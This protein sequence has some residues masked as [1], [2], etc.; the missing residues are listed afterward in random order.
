M[1]VCILE[2]YLNMQDVMDVLADSNIFIIFVNLTSNYAI[3][4]ILCYVV[5]FYSLYLI[6]VS[7]LPMH[8]D[9]LSPPIYDAPLEIPSPLHWFLPTNLRTKFYYVFS[10]LN[11]AAITL[12]YFENFGKG[13]NPPKNSKVDFDLVY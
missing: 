2:L 10:K 9:S 11:K 7:S 8:T 5:D 1:Y 12:S 4:L 13:Y 6:Y 3:V